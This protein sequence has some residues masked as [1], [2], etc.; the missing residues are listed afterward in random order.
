[1][2]S[3]ALVLRYVGQPPPVPLTNSHGMVGMMPVSATVSA[4]VC[5]ADFRELRR[6]LLSVDIDRRTV[7]LY[8]RTCF[9]SFIMN[10]LPFTRDQCSIASATHPS[11]LR[12]SWQI[13]SEHL[14]LRIENSNVNIVR[15]QLKSNAASN[16]NDAGCRAENVCQP[17][18]TIAPRVGSRT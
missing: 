5:I 7:T 1:M 15:G 4:E 11:S 10:F 14:E 8:H 6:W 16:G 18:L 3:D 17:R 13:W 9:G 12:E 2:L